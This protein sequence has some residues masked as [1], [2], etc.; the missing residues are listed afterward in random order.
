MSTTTTTSSTTTTMTISTTSTTALSSGITT[1]SS[2]ATTTATYSTSTSI[3]SS[4]TGITQPQYDP[5]P[6][7]EPNYATSDATTENAVTPVLMMMDASF[8]FSITSSELCFHEVANPMGERTGSYSFVSPEGEV[9]EVHYT[10][11]TDGY[12]ILN[13]EELPQELPFS[14]CNQSPPD[15]QLIPPPIDCSPNCM[16]QLPWQQCPLGC[17]SHNLPPPCCR[18]SCP[19]KC[20]RGVGGPVACPPTTALREC[21]M[22]PGCCPEPFD[23]V[24]GAGADF[25]RLARRY[26][27]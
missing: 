25:G 14:V 6:P 3:L 12:V 10:A 26:W 7:T 16:L 27:N 4:T 18:P 21:D 17:S 20:A 9:V 2:I 23:L 1:T 8:N 19:A 13:K 15:V 11:G 24:F 5:P 22:V